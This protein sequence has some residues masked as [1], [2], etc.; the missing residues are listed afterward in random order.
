[1]ASEAAADCRGLFP[2]FGGLRSVVHMLEEN[3]NHRAEVIR[4]SPDPVGKLLL[5]RYLA[6]S[7]FFYYD[8]LKDLVVDA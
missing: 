3:L 1:M 2:V 7:N 5:D 8:Q 4:E 6:V